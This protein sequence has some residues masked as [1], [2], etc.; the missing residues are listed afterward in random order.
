MERI[1]L[2]LNTA[3]QLSLLVSS[4]HMIAM[5]TSSAPMPIL[6]IEEKIDRSLRIKV[7]NACQFSC[8]FCHNEGTELPPSGPTRT[9]TLFD[10]LFPSCPPIENITV[11]DIEEIAA[12]LKE[13]SFFEQFDT[14][15]R[16]GY[17]EVHLTGG[18]PTLYSKLPQLITYLTKNGFLVKLT[19]NG[20]FTE[21]TLVKLA[22]AGLSGINFSVQSLDPEEF[23]ETQLREYPTKESA[24]SAGQAII[25]KVCDN[26]IKTNSLGLQAK[27]N[28]VIL[29][30]KKDTHRIDAIFD[31]ANKH[32]IPLSLLPVISAD[33]TPDDRTKLIESAFHYAHDKG[34]SYLKTEQALNNSNGIHRFMLPNG[35]PFGI[36]Y[37]R[38]YQ[39]EILCAAC[40]HFG[41]TS[42]TEN[43]YGARIEYRARKPFV[44]LCV[45]R[46]DEK[47]LMPLESFLDTPLVSL[48]PKD[49][50]KP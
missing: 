6:N 14:Y 39:P 29:D 47:A 8:K 21:R 4:W 9:S 13:T 1:S 36:K 18:E 34:A 12:S 16:L 19:S 23:L 44:R 11:P 2:S 26:I 33:Q 46:N 30:S 24:I 49:L 43:F 15:K 50:V 10:P 3:L 28:T 42:C 41:Q 22:D 7:T 45:Q 38:T 5:D 31:F 40:K 17:N 37:I 27:I 35:T 32:S 25:K 48:T 20:Q